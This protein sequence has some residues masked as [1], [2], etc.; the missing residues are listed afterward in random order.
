[1]VVQRDVCCEK[2]EDRTILT[3]SRW[4]DNTVFHL[5][6]NCLFKKPPFIKWWERWLLLPFLKTRYS[7]GEHGWWVKYKWWRGRFYLLKVWQGYRGP[8]ERG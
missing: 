6:P 4:T 2:Y 1:M 3:Q 5:P 8:D 7:R